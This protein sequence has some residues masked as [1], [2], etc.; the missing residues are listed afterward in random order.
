MKLLIVREDASLESRITV[1]PAFA[2]DCW[3]ISV[4]LFYRD[5]PGHPRRSHS[6]LINKNYTHLSGQIISPSECEQHPQSM[7]QRTGV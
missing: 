7:L 4:F 6:P 3:P 5:G 2:L 1:P